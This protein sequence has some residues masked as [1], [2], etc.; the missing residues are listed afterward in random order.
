MTPAVVD[1]VPV[2]SPL[3]QQELFGPAVAV[4]TADGIDEAIA[5]ANA[6]P[7]GLAAGLFTSDVK[8]AMRFAQEVD[9]GVLQ[10]NWS[11]LWRADLI[12]YGGLKASGVGK[13]GPEYAI[14]E[15][16]ERKAVI[17]HGLEPA[18]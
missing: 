2:D 3:V 8:A 16:T 7:Y 6:T 11:P 13:E 1:D 4:S 5:L 10:I 18:A 14:E 9:A 12:P 15:M 17:F